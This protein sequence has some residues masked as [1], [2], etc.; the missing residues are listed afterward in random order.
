MKKIIP[1]IVIVMISIIAACSA[2]SD[3]V[4]SAISP[5]ISEVTSTDN[6]EDTDVTS[7][8]VNS[9]SDIDN[10]GAT[11]IRRIR[12]AM[13]GQNICYDVKGDVVPCEGTGED[14]SLKAGIAWPDNR[15]VTGKDI[16]SDCV[17]DN[18]TGLMW[19]KSPDT[20]PM[21]WSDALS[22]SSELSL[23]GY[24]DWRLPNR[25][26]LRSLVN[27]GV[28]D[29][30]IW[31]NQQGFA[32]VQEDGR[33]WTSTTYVT[34]HTYD[35]WF[36]DMYDGYMF[37]RLKT[38]SDELYVL[39][40]RS[41]KSE[42]SVVLPMTGQNRCYDIEGEVI[43]CEGTGQDGDLQAGALWPVP[44]FTVGK[45]IEA[46]CVLDNLTGLMWVKSPDTTPIT[47][48]D[49]LSRSLELSLCGYTDW[50]LPNVNE[51]ESLLNAEEFDTSEWLNKSG[52]RDVQPDSYW[53]ST[54]HASE[55]DSAWVVHMFDGYIHPDGKIFDYYLLPVRSGK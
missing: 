35:A 39:P 5:D 17:T 13:T 30:S 26:E 16:E 6:S 19:V 2:K 43:P 20:A 34:E 51:L 8:A 24:T 37:A 48:S 22:Y 32:N 12:P 29:T 28:D 36:I 50:R 55:T 14:G 52:F 25:K 23:C 41:G 31:L 38:V 44:R 7:P 4:S 53:S 3:N 40:V 1:F 33:Y 15:F 10:N 46:E 45:G 54:T 9:S 21:A 49:A 47:W 27:Y 42:S 18:L 11:E